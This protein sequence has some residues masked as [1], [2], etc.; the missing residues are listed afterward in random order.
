MCKGLDFHYPQETT[1]DFAIG[2]AQF[3][4]RRALRLA[5]PGH[6]TAEPVP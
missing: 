5:G 1:S 4:L 2:S 3:L 6:L